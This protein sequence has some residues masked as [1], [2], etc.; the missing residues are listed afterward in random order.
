MRAPRLCWISVL[1]ATVAC[2]GSPTE[3]VTSEVSLS[4][5]DLTLALGDTAG[6]SAT[7]F[8]QSGAII[9]D[10]QIR[11]SSTDAV[12]IAFVT[13]N[14]LISAIG[15]GTTTI[16]A[17]YDGLSAELP[18]TVTA[19]LV[20]IASGWFHTCGVTVLGRATCWG[21]NASGKLG[22]GTLF[23][24]GTPALVTGLTPPTAT[25][26]AGGN[27]S[28]AL[29]GN[30]AAFCWG[31]NSR[32]QL[33]IGS[34]GGTVGENGESNSAQVSAVPVSGSLSFTTITIGDRHAC[35]LT[36]A[37]EVYCWGGGGWGQLGVGTPTSVCSGEPCELRPRKIEGFTFD[38]V[39]AGLQ[40]TC[41]IV[42]SGDAYCWGVN[43]SGAVGDSSRIDS[44]FAP[45]LVV[46]G[47]KYLAID[48]ADEHT[49][50]LTT[51][52]A[53]YCWGLNG[54]G[55]LG[56][57]SGFTQRFPVPVAGGIVFQ[58]VT[59]GGSHSCALTPDGDAYCWG[60]N[61]EGELGTGTRLNSE[62]P[63]LVNT[64]LQFASITAGATHNCGMA[65]TGDAYCWGWNITG[66]LGVGS[67]RDRLVPASVVG[68]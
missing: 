45:N 3:I 35:G 7:A 10:A 41:G 18:V 52:G 4:L 1:A 62:T 60:R 17:E 34:F 39:S 47:H 8:D 43:Q 49:C 11:W 68:Q 12:G 38:V 15:A 42:T 21:S 13:Q 16:I 33:G 53:A 28:C 56:E 61:F 14:G 40:H 66:Q 32:G 20:Q 37:G 67:G 46:G 50:A 27:S 23:G 26:S 64:S 22:T 19:D 29:D 5:T 58:T 57:G 9:S 44:F 65:K 63:V 36:S 48:L 25:V 55:Q 30:G 54:D 6:V 51:T 59:T 24:N 2:G 31:S